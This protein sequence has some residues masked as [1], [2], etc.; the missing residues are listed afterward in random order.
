M[1]QRTPTETVSPS[2]DPTPH[3]SRG[4]LSRR[5]TS[6]LVTVALALLVI[7]SIFIFNGL[8]NRASQ[9]PSGPSKLLGIDL[10]GAPAPDMTLKDQHGETIQLSRLRGKP[11]V[12]TFFDSHCPHEE[13]PL[14]AAGLGIAAK[15]LGSQASQVTWVAV[16]VNPADTP[17]SASAFLKNN[18]VAFPV[19]YRKSARKPLGFSQGM[20]G[21]L[22]LQT[23]LPGDILSTW[24]INTSSTVYTW[25]YT[26]SSGV[27]SG[28]ARCLSARCAHA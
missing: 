7:A 1:S 12:L 26:T 3:L 13:C 8:A 5:T 9:P 25:W 6:W 20:N 17:E 27:P 10:N 11:V 21:L 14:T 18:G 24:T 22:A 16:S 23:M 19:H 4:P 2:D 28:G 15:K